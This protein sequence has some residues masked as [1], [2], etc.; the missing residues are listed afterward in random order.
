[1]T[2]CFINP[3]LLFLDIIIALIFSIFCII[4]SC[5]GGLADRAGNLIESVTKQLG[6]FS[7]DR[8]REWMKSGVILDSL[9]SEMLLFGC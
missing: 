7:D 4:L 5:Q 6:F 8:L 9:K 2:S 3:F 1:M